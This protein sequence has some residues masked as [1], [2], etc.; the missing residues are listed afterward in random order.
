MTL[1]PALH[2]VCDEHVDMSRISSKSLF[3]SMICSSSV[4]VKLET[5]ETCETVF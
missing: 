1:S 4:S 3:K 2:V 5:C